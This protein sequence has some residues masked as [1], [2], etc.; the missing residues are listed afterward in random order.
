MSITPNPLHAQQLQA[1]LP[2]SRPTTPGAHSPLHVGFVG[3]GAMGL[4]M[5]RN[6]ATHRSSHPAGA[7][8]LLVYN[9]TKAKAEGL[10]KELGGDKVKI[11]ENAAEVA[12]EC[13][14][15]I[16]SLANDSAVKAIYEE[17]KDARNVCTLTTR[18]KR[19]DEQ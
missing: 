18:P 16:T 10:L 5:A 13:D 6:L 15:I 4:P 14:I 17:F 3:L 11:A 2:Y 1:E 8:P 19:R 12:R 9:R 7:P